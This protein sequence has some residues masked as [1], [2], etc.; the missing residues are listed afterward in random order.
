MKELFIRNLPKT[1]IFL[2][3]TRRNAL[4]VD[5]SIKQRYF[6]T[7]EVRKL[8]IGSGNNIIDGWLNSDFL[9]Y[10]HNVLHLDATKKFPFANDTFDYIF[11]EHMIEHVTYSDGM[12]M[13]NECHR[14]L[15]NNGTIRIT[16]PDLQFLIDIYGDDKSEIQREYIKWATDC[17]IQDAPDAED[18]FLVNNFV[19][20]WG[21]M[22]IY[23]E[24]TLRSSLER[25]G[26]SDVVR[27]E[28]NE[29]RHED[30]RGLE[31]ETRMPSGFL[32]LESVTLEGTKLPDS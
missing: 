17:F 32:A 2:K 31:N 15:R 13:L 29:S 8:Q 25:A 1:H 24:K 14:V 22:F 4:R 5:Q 27:C 23:D 3:K 16:T 7:F 19:R 12:A 11:S 30:L 20:D 9:P 28:I 18:T 26:F 21:H 10:S 6:S